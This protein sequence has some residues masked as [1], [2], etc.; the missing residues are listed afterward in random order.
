MEKIHAIF[1]T[2]E[3]LFNNLQKRDPAL[4]EEIRTGMV[5]WGRNE[6]VEAIK[7]GQD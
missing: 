1:Q 4:L 3:D 6:V 2:K 7:H 5:L